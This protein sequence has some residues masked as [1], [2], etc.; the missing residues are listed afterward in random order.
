MKVLHLC[1]GFA[2]SKVHANLYSRL[3]R[4]NINQTIYTTVYS[5]EEIGSNQFESRNSVFVYSKIMSNWLRFFYHLKKLKIKKDLEKK[6]NVK[7]IDCIHAVTLFTDGAQAYEINKKYGIPYVVTVRNTDINLF[8]E[9]APHTWRIGQKVLL[10]ASKVLFISKATELKFRNHGVIRPIL[11]DIQ[12]KFYVQ[13]NGVD[14]YWH[15]NISNE[16]GNP[17][18]ILYVGDFS[19]NKNVSRLI[20]AVL[21]LKKEDLFKNLHL[22]IVGGGNSKHGFGYKA[23][24]GEDYTMGVIKQHPETVTYL[25]P[26]YEKSKLMEVYRQNGIFAMPSIHETFGLVYIEALS[27]NLPIVYTKNQGIDQMVDSHAGVS[28][29]P[30]SIDEIMKAIKH[31]IL[32]YNEYS[33]QYVDF[34]M[35]DWDKIA[36][37]YIKIYSQLIRDSREIALKI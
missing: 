21:M 5:D 30:L 13:P 14:H 17:Y 29:D 1:N 37:N 27:Q 36:N 24:K 2:A 22:Y 11:K 16:K 20:Q 34:L 12:N 7:D 26:I 8:M 23:N 6:I 19:L 9:K 35:F 33:N 31:I 4:L 3:D 15:E 10:K 32:H 28:V 18:N 25:G